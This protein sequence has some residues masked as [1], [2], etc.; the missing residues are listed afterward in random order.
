MHVDIR[1]PRARLQHAIAPHHRER[2]LK[3]AKKKP[4]DLIQWVG[5][6][7]GI[8]IAVGITRYSVA[9]LGL[10]DRLAAAV[11]NLVIAVPN[12]VLLVGPFL[13]RRTRRGR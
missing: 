6:L 3:Q 11:A 1:H 5:F 10:V 4:F 8:V 9:G 13:F 12:L 2:T 7:V